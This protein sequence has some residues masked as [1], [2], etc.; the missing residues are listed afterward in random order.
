[1]LFKRKTSQPDRHI[2]SHGNMPLFRVFFHAIM[3]FKVANIFDCPWCAHSFGF[4]FHYH[5]LSAIMAA[6]PVCQRV[7]PDND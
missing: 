2:P 4:I 6:S 5:V 7:P 1:R 3:R